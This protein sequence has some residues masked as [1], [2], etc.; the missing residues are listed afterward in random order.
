MLVVQTLKG[1]SAAPN[2][3][4]QLGTLGAIASLLASPC[5]IFIGMTSAD[6]SRYLYQPLRSLI[7]GGGRIATDEL[8]R[9]ANSS[10]DSF[11]S[12]R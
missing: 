6:R 10:S 5:V 4:I 8:A 1:L 9:D 11:T 2:N 7:A 3:F 12:H